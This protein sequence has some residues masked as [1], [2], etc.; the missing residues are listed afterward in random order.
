MAASAS[1]SLADLSIATFADDV[2]ALA[3]RPRR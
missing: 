1:G 2:A 3:D